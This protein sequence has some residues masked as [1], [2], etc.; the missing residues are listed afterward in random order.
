MALPVA[1]FKALFAMAGLG[2]YWAYRLVLTAAH[3]LCVALLFALIYRRAGPV[4]A[5]LAAAPV[6]VLGA[7]WEDL[8][9]PINLGFVGSMFGGLGALL[10]LA[11]SSAVQAANRSCSGQGGSTSSS[12]RMRRWVAVSRS[13]A[14]AF[15]V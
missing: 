2:N 15:A 12:S 7:A 5:T 4:V 11:P 3:V 9:F 14:M 10:A 1:A 8:I 13:S 6:L